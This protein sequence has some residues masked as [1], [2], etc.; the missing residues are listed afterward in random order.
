M[1][2][3]KDRRRAA[4]EQA[5]D[6]ADSA[7]E[8]RQQAEAN[9]RQTGAADSHPLVS[10]EAERLFHELRVHKV[11][12][13][14]QNEELRRAHTALEAS[15]AQYFDL[16]DLAPVG[17]V[18]LDNRNLIQEANS[19]V[20]SLLGVPR[21]SV[22]K[23]PLSHFIVEADQDIYY[24]H[25]KRLREAGDPMLCELRLKR[26]DSAPIWAQLVMVVGTQRDTGE[27]ILRVA[28]SDIT[29]RKHA[30]EVL[31]ESEERFRAIFE[32]ANAGIAQTD[33]RG[34]FIRVNDQFCATLGYTR[35]ELLQMRMHDITHPEDLP[36][37]SVQFIALAGGGADFK[38]EKR[39]LRK[40]GSIMWVNNS[41]TGIRDADGTVQSLVAICTD[42]TE[43]KRAEDERRKLA[44]DLLQSQTKLRALVEELSRAEERERRRLA[45][46][47]HDYLAQTLALCRITLGRAAKLEVSDAVNRLL[48][49]AQQCVDSSMDY[50]RTM[51]AQLSPQVLYDFG[52]PAA[53]TWLGEKMQPHGLKV[54]VTGE[55]A[56]F[57]LDE[58]HAVLA[59]QCARELLWNVVK[60][61]QASEA[62][63]SYQGRESGLTVR[64]ADNGKGFDPAS[65]AQH[66]DGASKF[67]LFSV[68][69]R[70]QLQG[71]R[72]DVDSAPGRGTEAAIWLPTAVANN[73][74]R[75]LAKPAI[76]R[77]V[78][79]ADRQLRVELV[80]DHEVVRKGLRL[81]LEDHPDLS[82]VGEANDGTVAVE[83]ALELKPDVIVMDINLPRMNGIEATKLIRQALPDT[84]IVGLSVACATYTEQAMNALGAYCCIT[85]ERAAEEI[86]TAIKDAVA[87]RR[88]MAAH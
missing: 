28:I 46:E 19:R 14:M 20:E 75:E 84:A 65:V 71:G 44:E 32:Q 15:R 36:L 63:I 24:L 11:E 56:E 77:R 50:T 70:L 5:R 62:T 53:L 83:M 55:P 76:D 80:D 9:T 17:Y 88:R 64:V 25:C 60:H 85:K 34:R 45:T 26:Q 18:A 54:A 49:E 61:A 81:I 31:R 35:V 33:L 86:Y 48:A 68:R 2:S 66:G 78:V 79:T 73:A 12:L 51:M 52:L 41:V 1:S 3:K 39:Y 37:N 29:E 7:A 23:R 30:Q 47:L 69:E 16:Y 43:R 22:I 59:F 10:Q 72:L 38:I 74:S 42:V 27:K 58:D 67:G 21:A 4:V 82:I 57:Q 13:E 8:L 40:D 87:E 6:S